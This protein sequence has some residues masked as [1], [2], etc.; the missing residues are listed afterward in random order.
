MRVPLVFNNPSLTAGQREGLALNMDILPTA[1]GLLGVPFEDRQAR[2]LAQEVME[3]SQPVRENLLA[4]YHGLRFLCSQR[5]LVSDDGWKYI[6]S[7]G[8]YDELF[9]LNNDPHEMKNLAASAPYKLA[10]MRDVLMQET[11]RYDDPLR[12]CVS[13]FNGQWRTGSKQ[14]DATSAYLTATTEHRR[15]SKEN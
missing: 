2:N 8:D 12:D 6:F 14:F 11:A 5:V 1:L 7:P 10:V 15:K 3:V 4:E 9:D 13:K